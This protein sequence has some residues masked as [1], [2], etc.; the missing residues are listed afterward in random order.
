M[1]LCFGASGSV[2]TKHRHQS[3]WCAPEVH[4]FWPF[5]TKSSPSSTARVDRDSR[6]RCRRRGSLIPRHHEISARS[7]GTQ[8]PLLLLGRPVV[9]DRRGDD[10]EPLRVEAARDLALRHLLEVDHLL[11]RASRC[12][13]RA[14]AASPGRASRR[15]TACAATRRAHVGQVGARLLAARAAAPARR[16]VL[17]EPRDELGAGTPLRLRRTAV[18]RPA[19]A[20]RYRRYPDVRA[21]PGAVRVDFE[22]STTRSCCRDG[23]PLPRRAGADR[24]TSATCS[25]TSAGTTDDVWSGLGALGVTGLLVPEAHGGAGMGMVDMAVV[26]EELG[27]RGAPRPVRVDRGRSGEPRRAR[28]HRATATE[29]LPALASGDTIG[30]VAL[31]GPLARPAR[32]EHRRR[33][34]RLTGDEGARARRGRG[35]RRPRR[36]PRPTAARRVRRRRR[37]SPESRSHPRRPSTG[38]ASSPRSRSTEAPARRLGTGDAT[39]AVAET[40]DRLGVAAVVDGVGAAQRALELAVEYAKERRQFGRPIGSFQAVQ[41]LCADMLRAV[42][43]GTRRRRTTRAGRA[44]PPTRPSATAPRRWRRRS[45]P[46]AVHGRRVGASRCSA[47]S[48]SRGST[49][50]TSSTSGC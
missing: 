30:T 4:T 24:R 3:A 25:T 45:R 29:L 38:P 11:D 49:T 15:R 23:A 8:E 41:H 35:R 17:V 43:L 13:R 28:R 26:L 10:A 21:Q 42:E 18:A 22:R 37:R 20:T 1:P 36:P 5:T 50:S 39:G 33:V 9:L 47:A 32:A 6:G 48:A 7:V 2:R 46:T 31:S 44:T 34:R 40:V 12:G 14:R 27:P 16:Q 19:S